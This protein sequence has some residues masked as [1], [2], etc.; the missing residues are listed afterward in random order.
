MKKTDCEFCM[1]AAAQDAFTEPRI[2]DV[3]IGNETRSVVLWTDHTH[4]SCDPS[5]VR[6]A[7]DI[8]ARSERID[9]NDDK[10]RERAKQAVARSFTTYLEWQNDGDWQTFLDF[11]ADEVR[12]AARE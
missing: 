12:D 6:E 4:Y 3:T 1:Q 8:I 5:D 10:Y 7:R 9:I 2:V 11:V